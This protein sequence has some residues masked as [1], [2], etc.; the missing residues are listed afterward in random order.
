MIDREAPVVTIE[1][2]DSN[3]FQD[4]Y[5][6]DTR[7]AAITVK[8]I[9]Y[10]YENQQAEQSKVTES[11]VYTVR[12]RMNI[13]LTAKNAAGN[14]I[15]A[16]TESGWNFAD[17]AYHYVITYGEAGGNKVD[18]I[19]TSAFSGNDIYTRRASI[20]YQDSKGIVVTDYE[21]FVIDRE[22]PVVTFDYEDTDK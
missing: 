14:D 3:K 18:A 10:V 2:Y 15:T 20:S 11:D 19:F 8:D 4:H 6:R 5:Y 17:G 7:T 13:T 16:V 12:N 9:S 1:Y 21:S 22:A